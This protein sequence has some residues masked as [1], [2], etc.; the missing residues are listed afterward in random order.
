M[1]LSEIEWVDD[2]EWAALEQ[3]MAAAVQQ[4]DA[5]R[6]NGVVKSHFDNAKA[7]CQPSR[8]EPVKTPE[9][10]KLEAQG[11]DLQTGE[12]SDSR[13]TA[14][15][16]SFQATEAPR[17]GGVADHSLGSSQ[18]EWPEAM[19]LS[20]WVPSQRGFPGFWPDHATA[21][22]MGATAGE[23]CVTAAENRAT[24]EEGYVKTGKDCAT[25]GVAQVQKWTGGGLGDA[26]QEPVGLASSGRRD[27][28]KS[29]ATPL[30]ASAFT[31][32]R[33][34]AAINSS[35]IAAPVPESNSSA[36]PL[37]QI[38]PDP[39]SLP[40]LPKTIGDQTLPKCGQDDGLSV[41][42][43]P[44][45]LTSARTAGPPQEC[46]L[47]IMRFG[48]RIV[49]AVSPQEVEC[50]ARTLLEDLRG[51]D[52]CLGFD[53][54]WKVTFRRGET[55]QKAALIQLCPSG[56]CCYL[57]HIAHSGLTSS[58]RAL[59]D[60][61][62]VGKA[63]A[64]IYGDA[65]KLRRDFGVSM[66]GLRDL[67]DLANER[68]QPKD[69]PRKW[70]LTALAQEAML[71]QVEKPPKQRISDWERLPL[72]PDQR[73]YAATD[74]YASLRLYQVLMSLPAP[75]PRPILRPL[76]QSE[77]NSLVNPGFNPGPNSELNPGA[78]P[79]SEAWI[80]AVPEPSYLAPS[81][82]DVHRLHLDGLTIEEIAVKKG[83]RVTTVESY[84]VEATQAGLAYAWHRLGVSDAVRERIERAV[85]AELEVTE[86]GAEVENRVGQ[87]LGESGLV[88]DPGQ[89]N[90]VEEGLNRSLVGGNPGAPS[91]RGRGVSSQFAG[92]AQPLLKGAESCSE[93]RWAGGSF[94]GLRMTSAGDKSADCFDKI[95]LK[96]V[97]ERIP[98][99]ESVTFPQV[100]L[101]VAH[102]ARQAGAN[103]RRQ[104]RM[105]LLESCEPN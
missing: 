40:D 81:K 47:P 23:R 87:G 31:V 66:G 91:E 14:S 11:K 73:Q 57:F 82:M 102:I 99:E 19:S 34:V 20:E 104:K 84:L 88:E 5:H 89:P 85:K 18:H 26:S 93:D 37:P 12:T 97:M 96:A 75:P 49:Y 9:R 6:R 1:D 7:V 86:G 39:D 55:P 21:G 76:P 90:E 50:S 27:G 94:D 2:K 63:G 103:M 38:C 98:P 71:Q 105:R 48:G 56:A 28:P 72:S 74:A 8:L 54:E 13:N 70:S 33:P 68:L 45:W 4:R 83:V 29:G 36:Q 58:L 32:P 15:G 51:G 52:A 3:A 46:T 17:S 10:S 35:G 69:G 101:V 95:R 62:S 43:L 64:G 79:T 59:L 44:A 25:V 92:I 61:Q 78:E 100:R 30:A 16:T 41:R 67:S 24:A 42:Q 65:Q 80:P 60:E 22:A 77:L 53:I